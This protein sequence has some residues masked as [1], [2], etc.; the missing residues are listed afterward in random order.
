MVEVP[1]H[2]RNV[3]V[4]IQFLFGFVTCTEEA[5]MA[6]HV[7]EVNVSTYRDDNIIVGCVPG[8]CEVV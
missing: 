5:E 1:D 6:P 3:V 2:F 8:D 4:E 7:E